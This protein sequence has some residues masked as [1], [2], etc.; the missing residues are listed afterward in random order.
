MNTTD[1]RI[2]EIYY[3]TGN[4]ALKIRAESVGNNPSA[5]VIESYNNAP[6]IR[7][8]GH[9]GAWNWAVF[10]PEIPINLPSSCKCYWSL[11]PL[12]CTCK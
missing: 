1:V 10:E 5:I 2:G 3:Y 8:I 9:R 6:A 12:Y 11:H 4:P 7:R